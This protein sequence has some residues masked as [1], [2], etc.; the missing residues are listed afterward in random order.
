[1][2][3]TNCSTLERLRQPRIGGIVLF[4]SSITIVLTLIL[5]YFI[6]GNWPALRKSM[7]LLTYEV[8]LLI[9]VIVL[10]IAIHKATG[11]KTMLNYYLGLSQKPDVFECV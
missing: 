4:D 11:T 2:K 7:S 6:Y 5:G 1:M 8:M 3:K 9:A 10:G